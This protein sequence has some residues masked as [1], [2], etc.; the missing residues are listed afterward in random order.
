MSGTPSTWSSTPRTGS[1]SSSPSYTTPR[2]QGQGSIYP[3]PT[4]DEA[5][6]FGRRHGVEDGSSSDDDEEWSGHDGHS[7]YE[8]GVE[9]SY[10]PPALSRLELR[11]ETNSEDEHEYDEDEMRTY[12]QSAEDYE[13]QDGGQEHEDEHCY[14][15]AYTASEQDIEPELALNLATHYHTRSAESIWRDVGE[16]IR[17]TLSPVGQMEVEAMSEETREVWLRGQQSEMRCTQPD[18]QAGY[19][20]AQPSALQNTPPGWRDTVHESRLDH[21]VLVM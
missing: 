5:S 1:K 19:S 3:P 15:K 21:D 11:I 4:P 16:D 10:A 20:Y 14:S 13:E 6:K 8:Y 17:Q 18:T 7:G 12:R 9:S 2:D